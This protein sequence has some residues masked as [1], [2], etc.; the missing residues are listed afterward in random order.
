MSS[1]PID[2]SEAALQPEKP[3]IIGILAICYYV[4]GALGGMTCLIA[5]FLLIM[6]IVLL[7]NGES[8]ANNPQ[9]KEI[10]TTVLAE[11]GGRAATLTPKDVVVSGGLMYTIIGSIWLFFALIFTALQFFVASSISKGKRY[12]LC[13]A[14]SCINILGIPFGTALGV[15]AVIFLLKPEAKQYFESQKG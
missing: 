5:L 11:Q 3:K 13:I 14:V 7:N 1:L 12:A 15:T 6:G 4:F 8:F 9:F 10:I 2:S